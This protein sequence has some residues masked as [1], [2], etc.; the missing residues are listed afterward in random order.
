M[1]LQDGPAGVRPSYGQTQWAQQV[2]LAATW[3][4][5]LIYQSALAMGKEFRDLGVNVALAPVSGGPIGRA[6][7][8][9]RNYEGVSQELLR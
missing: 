3:D 9:G 6:P 7:L 8:A 4:T 5:D 2:T 1:C